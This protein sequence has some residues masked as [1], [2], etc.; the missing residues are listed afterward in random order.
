MIPRVIDYRI[1]SKCNMVCPFCFGPTLGEKTDL[2]KLYS[3]M[4][5]LKKHGLKHVVLTGGEPTLS[6][7]FTNI[8]DMLFDLDLEIALQSNGLFWGNLQLREIVLKKCSWIAFPIE[9]PSAT[10]HN[11]MRCSQFNHHSLIISALEDISRISTFRPK[12]KIGT[13]V[14]KKNFTS[15]PFL[16]DTLPIRPDVWKLYQLSRS[17]IN[18]AFYNQ[19]R[20][21]N[22]S[23]TKLI[24]SI[25]DTHQN[26]ATHIQASYEVDRDKQYL[27]LEPDGSLMTIRRGNEVKIGDYSSLSE[28]LLETIK[29]NVDSD[30]V[31]K[32]FYCSFGH[33]RTSL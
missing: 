9:S 23:F 22:E 5:F 17:R 2:K 28:K 14:C 7:N 24:S 13:V 8:L 27:F 21:D 12:I 30:W 10:I 26:T 25:K 19:F 18:K 4:F 16:L 29:E 6:S 33:P 32:N 31:N 3:F 20:I 15:I 1:N 11:S